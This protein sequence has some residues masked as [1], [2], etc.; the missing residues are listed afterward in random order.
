MSD[1]DYR[2]LPEEITA[3]LRVHWPKQ[4]T[5]PTDA[6]DTEKRVYGR[7][8]KSFG[9]N[10]WRIM[11]KGVAV[12]QIT[13]LLDQTAN[14]PGYRRLERGSILKRLWTLAPNDPL[15]Q[16]PRPTEPVRDPVL[17]GKNPALQ[18]LRESRDID[19]AI[20][21]HPW[22]GKPTNDGTGRRQIDRP[23]WR[24]MHAQFHRTAQQRTHDTRET[25]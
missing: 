21:R 2:P 6:T 12:E 16:P 22:F 23:M 24:E 5:L 3:T 17:S 1:N 7:L 8:L 4:F 13:L 25:A 11:D 18:A 20:S 15:P 19:D 9:R 10:V 14:E